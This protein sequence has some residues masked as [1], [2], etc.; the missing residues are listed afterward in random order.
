VESIDRWRRLA[1]L[2]EGRPSFG[3]GNDWKVDFNLVSE[4]SES[5][6]LLRKG[7]ERFE[8]GFFGGSATGFDV[9]STWA[10]IPEGDG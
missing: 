1:S 3:G 4:R 6:G 7:S 5:D 8:V 9:A 2:P 10:E